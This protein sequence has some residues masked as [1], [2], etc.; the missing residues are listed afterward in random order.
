MKQVKPIRFICLGGILS[1]VTV[2]LQAA[3]VYLPALGLTLSPVSTL[4]V[5]LATGINAYLGLMVLIA[6]TLILIM[7]SIQE[8]MIFLFTIGLIGLILAGLIYKNGFIISIILSAAA[9][10]TGMVILTYIVAVPGFVE[11]TAS[12]SLPT[13]LIIYSIFSLFYTFIW[14]TFLRRFTHRLLCVILRQ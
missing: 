5:A 3:P 14:A 4:P 2:I 11:L 7:V 6:S 10:T 13:T 1:A 9:L 8:A 12:L